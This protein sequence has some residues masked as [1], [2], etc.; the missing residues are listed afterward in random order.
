MS[1]V[2]TISAGVTATI[3]GSFAEATSYLGA[4]GSEAAQ[5]WRDL[6]DDADRKRKLV[7]ATRA[8]NRLAYTEDYDTFAERDVLDLGTGDGDAAFPF[9]AGCYEL[10][11]LAA[12]D[13]SVLTVEDQGSNIAS[14]SA[15]GASVTYF[16]PK[17]AAKGTA[18]ILPPV[19]MALIG[20]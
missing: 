17:S 11:A 12:A 16:A 9:R 3:Y 6:A 8:L 13:P 2:V 19:V 15:G 1:E 18:S 10:A 20:S 4:S 14:V 7:D 5:A